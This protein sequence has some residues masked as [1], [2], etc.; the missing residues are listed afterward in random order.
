MKTRIILFIDAVIN[1]GLGILLLI[2][3][4]GIIE[5]LG[6]PSTGLNFYPN[7]LGAVLFGIGI[8]LLIEVFKKREMN[9]GLGLWGAISINICGGIV[10]ALWLIS[11]N[12]DLPLRGMII[13]WVLVFILVGISLIEM[14]LSLLPH[15]ESH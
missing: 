7:I 15:H 13:L 11:G 2:F 12:L 1:F 5:F 14:I 9:T 3:T 6:I 10:L 4:P 8:A